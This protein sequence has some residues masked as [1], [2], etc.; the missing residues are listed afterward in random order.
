MSKGGSVVENLKTPVQLDVTSKGDWIRLGEQFRTQS[1]GKITGVVICK[2]LSNNPYLAL[3]NFR[4]S[5]ALLSRPNAE[6][7]LFSPR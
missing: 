2:G 7:Y 5:A 3:R 4:Q 6:R 1:P